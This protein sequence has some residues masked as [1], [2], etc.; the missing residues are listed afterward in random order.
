MEPPKEHLLAT[1]KRVKEYILTDLAPLSIY[2]RLRV[3]DSSPYMFFL[4][5]GDC[6]LVGSSP[7]TMV[8]IQDGWVYLRPIAG[9]RGRSSDPRR[10][11]ELEREMLNSNKE[12]AAHIMLVDLT[13]NDAGRVSQHGSVAVDRYSHVMHIVSQVDGQL[14]PELNAED[15]FP[16]GIV[17]GALKVRGMKITTELEEGLRGRPYAGAVSFFGPGRQMDTCIAI[18]IIQLEGQNFTLQVGSSIISDSVPEMEFQENA[19]KAPKESPR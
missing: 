5:R 15:A 1:M 9:T 3:K 2:C 10:Y 14:H 6:H 17:S 12:L 19:H 13:R 4:K 16:A 7:E 11:R 18:R 8:Q